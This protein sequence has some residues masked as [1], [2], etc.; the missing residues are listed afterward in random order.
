MRLHVQT[1][2]APSL[3]AVPDLLRRAAQ[4]MAAMAQYLL[5]LPRSWSCP[6]PSDLMP[7]RAADLR[8]WRQQLERHVD[9]EDRD[10]QLIQHAPAMCC[11]WANTFS[12]GMPVPWKPGTA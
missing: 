5:Q 2:T 12:S 9:A 7:L 4:D 1:E 11:S 8:A 3:A 6:L 10:Q